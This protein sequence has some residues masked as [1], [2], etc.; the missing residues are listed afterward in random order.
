LDRREHRLL[1]F[2]QRFDQTRLANNALQSAAPEGIM[3]RHGD[4]D[5]CPAGL[6][7]HDAVTAA[8]THCDES[9]RFENLAGFGA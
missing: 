4:G 1:I 9:V 7:L 5:G 8:L 6:Q 3:E 2:K